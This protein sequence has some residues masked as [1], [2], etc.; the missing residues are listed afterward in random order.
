[1]ASNAGNRNRLMSHSPSLFHIPLNRRRA[2]R[3]L[4][5]TG[6]GLL[7]R[8]AFAE[9]LTLTPQLTQ[10]PFFPDHLPLD[11]DNDLIHV[12]DHLSPA[13]GTV[14]NIGGRLLDP[15]GN[16]LEFKAFDDDARVFAR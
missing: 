2:L 6:A 10:G 16:A 11:Q 7:A 3:S 15:S 8:G 5:F 1:M 14:T 12:T 4:I 9:A 13:L